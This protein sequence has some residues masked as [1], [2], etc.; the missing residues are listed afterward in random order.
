[1]GT[2]KK[3][4]TSTISRKGSVVRADGREIIVNL[5]NDRSFL[6]CCPNL[7]YLDAGLKVDIN[8]GWYIDKKGNQIYK[9]LEQPLGYDGPKVWRPN[10][11]SLKSFEE[12]RWE[13]LKRFDRVIEKPYSEAFDGLVQAMV[14]LGEE[15]ICFI[16]KDDPEQYW[17]VHC[18]SHDY[19][20]HGISTNK[21]SITYYKPYEGNFTDNKRL[22]DATYHY[23]HMSSRS[24]KKMKYRWWFNDMFRYLL[25]LK[26]LEKMRDMSDKR[27]RPV[28]L[29]ITINDRQYLIGYGVGDTNS[30]FSLN[31]LSSPGGE[32]LIKD[33][34]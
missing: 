14:K 13:F 17:H 29:D 31:I 22:I 28:F 9:F 8:S 16:D 6:S 32:T 25:S 15:E 5:P 11:I 24:Y 26:Y 18:S 23:S 33:V 27:S 20:S 4:D 2:R 21:N 30:R 19:G 7:D 12:R 34:V 10:M 1:M 3:K